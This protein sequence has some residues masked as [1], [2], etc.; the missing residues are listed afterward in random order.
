MKGNIHK[1]VNMNNY[2]HSLQNEFNILTYAESSLLYN[3]IEYDKMN[4]ILLDD[5]DIYLYVMND[6]YCL[7][8]SGTRYEYGALKELNK[9][10]YRICNIL[11]Y[12]DI[13]RGQR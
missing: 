10:L 1:I 9:Q 13:E 4:V 2:I 7:F 12:L 8:F 6:N 11:Y 5:Y 3:Y